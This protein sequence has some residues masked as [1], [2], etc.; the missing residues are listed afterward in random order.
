MD[1]QQNLNPEQEQEQNMEQDQEKQPLLSMREEEPKKSGLSP[2][3]KK[4]IREWVSSIAFALIAFFLIRTFLFQVIAVKGDSMNST[5]TDGDRMIVTVL[6]MKLGNPERGDVI[7]CHYPNRDRDENFVKRVIGVPGDT[8]LMA[9]GITYVNG[10]PLDETSYIDNPDIRSYGPYEVPEGY[11]FVLG[12]NRNNSSD[13][14]NPNVG[15][16]AR[17]QFIGKARYVFFPFDHFGSIR[18]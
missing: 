10:E 11:Y 5:L 18:N 6:D 14:R 9:N 4:E 3:A 2:K 1:E 13:S 15:F 7:I 12:D 16:I 8:V 17:D